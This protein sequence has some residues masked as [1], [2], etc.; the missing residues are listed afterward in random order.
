VEP[1]DEHHFLKIWKENATNFKREPGFISAQL[2]KGI[3][4]STVFISY[5]VWES[6]K[7]VKNAADKVLGPDLELVISKFPDSLVHSSHLFK[8]V[9][10]PGICED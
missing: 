3:G 6:P 9:A 1:K 10:V 4:K 8:K 5:A 2:H 7:H